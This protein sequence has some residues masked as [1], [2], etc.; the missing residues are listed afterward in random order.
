MN[1]TAYI[2]WNS[3]DNGNDVADWKIT[4]NGLR[5][6][7]STTTTSNAPTQYATALHVRGRYGFQ[8]AS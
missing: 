1:S 7:S 8:L 3:G 4:G 2:S 6:I 5:I